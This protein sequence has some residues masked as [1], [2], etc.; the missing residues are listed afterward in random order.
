M[1]LRAF[2]PTADAPALRSQRSGPVD[3]VL[4]IAVVVVLAGIAGGLTSLGQLVLPGLLAPLAN[5]SS[6]WTLLAVGV[7]AATR[8]PAP[9][10]AV[11]G[12]LA[13]SA[14]TLG[15]TV[16]SELRGIAFDPAFW[17]A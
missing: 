1:S 5:S 9:R 15:Y 17:I 2:S 16:V 7:V 12:L 4:S 6:G 11:L 10:A 14:L 13:F 3:W 8:A